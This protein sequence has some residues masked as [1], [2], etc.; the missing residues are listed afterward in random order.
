ML[1]TFSEMAS[2]LSSRAVRS[3]PKPSILGL[4]HSSSRG[5]ETMTSR[6]RALFAL[7]LLAVPALTGVP[8]RADDSTAVLKARGPR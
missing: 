2:A 6:R 4:N 3:Y 7:A 8:A 1:R 5:R